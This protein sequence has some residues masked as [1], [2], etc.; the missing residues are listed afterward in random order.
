MKMNWIENVFRDVRHALRT[1]RK[2]P[3]VAAVQPIAGVANSGKF[4]S[5]EPRTEAGG[6]TGTS[7]LE[8]LDLQA[9]LRLVS[10]LFATRVVPCN[11]GATGEAERAFGMQVSGNYFSALRL[12]PAL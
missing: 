2:M 5:L 6:Y 1:I 11:G 12:Q 7:W 4:F 9:R 10:D 8:F 3:A